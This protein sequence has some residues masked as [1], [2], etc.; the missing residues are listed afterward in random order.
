MP[1][2][3]Y[4]VLERCS[5]NNQCYVPLSCMLETLD[6][7]TCLCALMCTNENSC[8]GLRYLVKFLIIRL[9]WRR[10]VTCQRKSLLLGDTENLNFLLI[11]WILW[12][13]KTQR[14]CTCFKSKIIVYILLETF[15]KIPWGFIQAMW[16]RDYYVYDRNNSYFYW[17]FTWHQTQC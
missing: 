14:Q 6:F 4:F 12:S 7:K 16:Y 5:Y 3:L 9:V 11:K 15:K 10:L 2:L 1:N 8:I 13:S 17:R